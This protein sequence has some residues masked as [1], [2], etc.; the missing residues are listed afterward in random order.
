[1]N[2][3][4]NKLK[5][6]KINVWS[7]N[8]KLSASMDVTNATNDAAL[9]ADPSDSAVSTAIDV[10]EPLCMTVIKWIDDAIFAIGSADT[11]F[12]N[13]YNNVVIKITK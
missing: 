5:Q 12:N 11:L 1:M 13:Y 6:L 2:N 8:I 4:S 9:W 10:A 7:D 3:I